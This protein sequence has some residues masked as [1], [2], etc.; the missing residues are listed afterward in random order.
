MPTVPLPENVSLEHLR[1][2]AK[3]V[4]QLVASGDQGAFDLLREFHPRFGDASP[5]VPPAGFKL[6]DAQ[7]TVARLYGHS[8]W[9]RLR[10]HLG[11]ID[12]H[13]RPVR[14]ARASVEQCRPLRAELQATNAKGQPASG[15]VNEPAIQWSV[16]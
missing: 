7:L 9:A 12:V 5:S 2:Q 4:R 14:S 13:T 6:A 1:K 3:L 15:T 10:D 16:S 11:L 8:S